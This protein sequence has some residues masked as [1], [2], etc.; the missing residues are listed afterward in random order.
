MNIMILGVFDEV[1]GLTSYIN[2]FRWSDGLGVIKLSSDFLGW[3][4]KTLL[5][6]GEENGEC[7]VFFFLEKSFYIIENGLKDN[8]LLA[9]NS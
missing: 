2:D 9:I 5:L 7:L 4:W 3:R 6:W 8:G 1:P